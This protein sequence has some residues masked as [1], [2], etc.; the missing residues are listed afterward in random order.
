MKI[1]RLILKNYRKYEDAVFYFH[2]RFTILIGDNGAGKT[3]I[4]DAL[5][6]MLATYFQGSGIKVGRN[7]IGRE[8][9]RLMVTEKGGQISAEPQQDVSVSADGML[10]DI[11]LCWRRDTGDRGGKAKQLVEIGADDRKRISK[12]DSFDLPVMLYYGSGR[13]WDIHR[14][15]ETEKPGSQLDAY[16]FCLDP[17]SDQKAF[18]KWFKKLSLAAVQKNSRPTPALDVVKKAVMQCIPDAEDFFH[19][20]ERDEPVIVFRDG[21]VVFFNMLSDGYRNMV[22]MVA[23]IAHR[24]SRLNPHLGAKA[25]EMSAGI[26]LIDEIDLHLHPN[27]QRQV[28]GDLQKAFPAMQFVA[29]TH[30]PFIIQSA[31][32][33][34]IIDLNQSSA[35]EKISGAVSMEAASPGAH[36]AYVNRS[37]EDIA[38]EVMGVKLPQRSRRYQ[39]MYEAAQEYY[40]LLNR[41]PPADADEKATLK[42]KL[43]ALAAPFSD[44]VA[45]HAFLEMERLAAGFGHDSQE[46]R[47]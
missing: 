15:I 33:G 24:A 2:K 8:D 38:E 13:L 12:G 3:T 43:D 34:E 25:A 14:D 47:D 28:V 46:E 1:S 36:A 6:A 37:I 41:T 20:I 23:D 10:R 18:Q 22:A 32:E 27:W 26:I 21:E 19:D 11:P 39:Q 4:L 7:T 5:A 16:R 40:R 42:R 44:N 9:R 35:A 31:A 30:S 29:T 45:Y 17:K